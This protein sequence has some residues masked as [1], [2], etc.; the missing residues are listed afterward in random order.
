MYTEITQFIQYSLKQRD[1]RIRSADMALNH[2]D[3]NN[4]G[5]LTMVNFDASTKHPMG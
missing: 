2:L 4:M 3:N 1:N 5:Q